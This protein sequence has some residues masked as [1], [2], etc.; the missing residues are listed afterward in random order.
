MPS[1]M[2][3]KFSAPMMAAT[4]PSCG[5]P[6]VGDD[7]W[8]AC[9]LNDVATIPVLS[10]RASGTVLDGISPAALAHYIVACHRGG[11]T[12]GRREHLLFRIRHELS[13]GSDLGRRGQS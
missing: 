11:T 5:R 3:R 4:S 10:H 8:S 1:S 12:D 13:R 7:E 6:L 9:I 2:Q